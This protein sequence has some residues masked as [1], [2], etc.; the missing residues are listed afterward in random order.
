MT[1]FSINI[2]KFG[3]FIDSF[4][5]E[6]HKNYENYKSQ[7]FRNVHIDCR[8]VSIFIISIVHYSNNIIITLYFFLILPFL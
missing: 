6:K 1:R 3:Y 5:N 8:P 7:V 4:Q 2:E